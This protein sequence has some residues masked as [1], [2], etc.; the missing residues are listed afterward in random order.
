MNSSGISSTR[1]AGALHG[2]QSD[3]HHSL[4]LLLY[5]GSSRSYRTVEMSTE[6]VSLRISQDARPSLATLA[7]EDQLLICC[8]RTHLDDEARQ[9]ALQLLQAPL[10]WDVI[11][12]NSIRHNVTPLFCWGLE[13]LP[14]R[15]LETR[16]PS[17][18]LAELRRL[19]QG[20]RARHERL[21]GTIADLAE[22]F[23]RAGVP[24]M[25]LKDVQLACTVYPEPGLRTLGDIDLLIH[26]NDYAAAAACLQ[27]L[28]FVA[29][30]A[31][32][33]PYRLKYAWA[34]FFKRPA[35]NVWLDLQW[36]VV[37][38]E[39]DAYHE[40]NFDFE[41]ERM[42]RGAQWLPLSHGAIRVPKPED[43]LFH[44]CQHLEGHGYAELVLF[45]DI[46]EFLRFYQNQLDWGYLTGLAE[47]YDSQGTLHDVL[48]LVQ[49]L[50]QSHLPE[51]LLAALA[52]SYSQSDLFFPLYDSL[53]TLHNA[54]DEIRLSVDPPTRV[55]REFESIA[56]RE[57]HGAMQAFRTLDN[58]ART[59]VAKGGTTVIYDGIPSART[60]PDPALPAFQDVDCFVLQDNLP[61]MRQVLSDA[62]F[63]PLADHGAERY[64][65][66]WNAASID[67]ALDSPTRMDVRVLIE[68]NP[69]AV[70]AR[71]RNAAS[72]RDTAL[73]SLRGKLLGRRGD[74][75]TVLVPVTIH[76]LSPEDMTLYLIAQLGRALSPLLV[77][78]SPLEWLRRYHGA[79]DWEKLTR[80]AK[81]FGI[82][83]DLC[84]GTAILTAFAEDERILSCPRPEKGP[85]LL[86]RARYT[87]SW[88]R[89]GPLR[90]AYFYALSL[91]SLESGRD[92]IAFM[93]RRPLFFQ[94]AAGA[95]AFLRRREPTA[96]DFAYWIDSTTAK[97]TDPA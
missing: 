41:I 28:G 52:P 74:E 58:L 7:T 14:A 25:G 1:A 34:H 78:H 70:L 4:G 72:V 92:R 67:P 94:L 85:H 40:G 51:G 73:R 81:Q 79:I 35:D 90:T 95:A 64:A 86:Q 45:C 87:D 36:N 49:R 29:Q 21:F 22:A 53:S 12:E 17:A 15:A 2:E 57:A 50:F 5:Y 39:W 46:A 65:R 3:P 77:L 96:R 13:Q 80:T 20:S 18:A 68:S 32:D 43:M 61:L 9:R 66:R 59:F 16:V 31:P 93:L 10:D 82:E 84:Q 27:Q 91:L 62:G 88:G 60:W 24:V 26:R 33:I 63:V 48:F 38:R 23:A 75:A 54:L 76:P 30:P 47:K 83:R 44:L 11:V 71:E 42:W 56:R 6:H 89:Y 8:S 19:L 97:E 55:M 69:A 37:Q